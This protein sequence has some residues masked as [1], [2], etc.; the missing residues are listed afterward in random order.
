MMSLGRSNFASLKCRLGM[1]SRTK[2][3]SEG[4]WKMWPSYQIEALLCSPG[5]VVELTTFWSEHAHHWQRQETDMLSTGLKC[6]LKTNI[7]SAKNCWS[8]ALWVNWKCIGV[9][10]CEIQRSELGHGLRSDFHWRM[11]AQILSRWGSKKSGLPSSHRQG[12]VFGEQ[13]GEQRQ[14]L[15]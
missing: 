11:G 14:Q 12:T 7:Q 10:W 15:W 5:A 13:Q 6:P 8:K 4:G 9:C 1:A 2:I 3:S